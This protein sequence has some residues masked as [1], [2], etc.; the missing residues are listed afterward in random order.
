MVGI[1]EASE[2]CA[3]RRHSVSTL[4]A[5]NRPAVALPANGFGVVGLSGCNRP[6]GANSPPARPGHPGRPPGRGPVPRRRCPRQCAARWAIRAGP[7]GSR[8][9]GIARLAWSHTISAGAGP[10]SRRT[11]NGAGSSRPSNVG[12]PVEVRG[13]AKVGRGMAAGRKFTGCP[14][15]GPGP[16]GCA[17]KARRLCRG[18]RTLRLATASTRHRR[19]CDTIHTLRRPRDLPSA[20]TSTDT[21]GTGR[22]GRDESAFRQV[23]PPALTAALAR[24]PPGRE[25]PRRRTAGDFGHPTRQVAVRVR[26]PAAVGAVALIRPFP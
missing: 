18:C 23:E 19:G 20:V 25:R 14:A 3:A 17:G 22:C 10:F 7:G 4:V 16:R 8:L 9:F 21:A 15:P 1:E 5:G 6:P 13:M 26:D 11:T 24:H 12:L 2:A